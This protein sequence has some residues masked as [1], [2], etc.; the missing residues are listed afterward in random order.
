MGNDARVWKEGIVAGL[1]G[2]AAVAFWFLIVDLIAGGAFATPQLL[3]QTLFSVLGKGISWSPMTYVAAYTVVHVAAFVIVGVV[4]SKVV[5]A[6]KRTPGVL[7]G[8]LLLFVVFE[9]GFYLAMMFL[10]KGSPLGNLA[11]YQIGAANLLAAV[12][13]GRYLWREHPE[14]SARIEGVLSGK[15]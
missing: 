12:L 6:S 10:A 2:A 5:E 3:G 9:V 15:A 8:L 7:A 11:W 4:V 14:L 13:M 1:L